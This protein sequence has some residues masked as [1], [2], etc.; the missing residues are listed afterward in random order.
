MNWRFAKIPY[1]TALEAA[2][3]GLSLEDEEWILRRFDSCEA[4]KAERGLE[5]QN[6]EVVE[7]LQR[8]G[9]II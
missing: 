7:L 2:Q 8:H 9:A 3:V 4:G 1:P 5:E 6:L